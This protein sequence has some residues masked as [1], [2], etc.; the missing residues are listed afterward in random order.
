MLFTF[1]WKQQHLRD[2]RSSM[3]NHTGGNHFAKSIAYSI[4]EFMIPVASCYHHVTFY[5]LRCLLSQIMN[6]TFIQ[7]VRA[8]VKLCDRKCDEKQNMLTQTTQ[9]LLMF[10]I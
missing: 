9:H 3:A 5:R 4:L 10:G 2:N 8:F 7:I 6:E 1:I